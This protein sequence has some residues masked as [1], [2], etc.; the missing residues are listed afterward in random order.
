MA[1]SVSLAQEAQDI[2]QDAINRNFLPQTTYNHDKVP[3]IVTQICDTIV[4]KLTQQSKL[5]RKYVV[6]CSILQK[7]GSGFSQVS[8][9]AWNKDSDG[10]YVVK[11]ESN[12]MICILSIY[13]VTM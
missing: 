10:C 11:T 3:Q 6:H 1:G 7:N 12:C 5:P 4:Q 9:V 8:C 13:G 2:V